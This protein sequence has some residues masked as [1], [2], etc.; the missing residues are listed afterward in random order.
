MFKWIF[1]AVLYVFN[2]VPLPVRHFWLQVEHFSLLED[3][4]SNTIYFRSDTF[5]LH[6]ASDRNRNLALNKKN[7]AYPTDVLSDTDMFPRISVSLSDIFP[8]IKIGII[9]RWKMK[10]NGTS[11]EFVGVLEKS[12]AIIKYPDE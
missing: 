9:I 2:R 3:M 1:I 8:V 7:L 6:P 12:N 4:L 11:Q 5:V 10:I